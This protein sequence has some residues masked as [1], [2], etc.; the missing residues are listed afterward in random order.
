MLQFFWVFSHNNNIKN[1]NEY[2]KIAFTKILKK[3]FLRKLNEK[4]VNE[5]YKMYR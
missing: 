1:K 5:N 2:K 4:E 3:F